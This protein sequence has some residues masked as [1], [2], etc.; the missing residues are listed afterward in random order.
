MSGI[1][2]PST[3]GTPTYGPFSDGTARRQ[4]MLD[5][6][7]QGG[8]MHRQTLD[9]ILG[10]MSRGGMANTHRDGHPGLGY[11]APFDVSQ[12]RRSGNPVINTH[13]DGDH[14]DVIER[15][16]VGDYLHHR[17]YRP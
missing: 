10:G 13:F 8:T 14:Y 17:I 2:P 3:F 11:V 7:F 9:D 6:P 15:N 4:D 16:S 1:L 12:L 5:G